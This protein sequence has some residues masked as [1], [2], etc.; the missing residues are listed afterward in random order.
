MHIPP[1]EI[2][3]Y[4]AVESS[5]NWIKDSPLYYKIQ[6]MRRSAPLKFKWY[7]PLQKLENTIVLHFKEGTPFMEVIYLEIICLW[8]EPLKI[9]IT[10]RT[11]VGKL[12][13]NQIA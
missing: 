7:S 11:K 9:H 1:I 4:W 2:A 13:Y 8:T 10:K 3:L 12:E 6:Q 5:L